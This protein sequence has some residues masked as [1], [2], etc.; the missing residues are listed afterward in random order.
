MGRLDVCKGCG[1]PEAEAD[2]AAPVIKGDGDLGP[3]WYCGECLDGWDGERNY[4]VWERHGRHFVELADGAIL[5]QSEGKGELRVTIDFLK[6]AL[7]IPADVE[8]RNVQAEP[9]DAPGS[10]RLDRP[11][12]E[13]ITFAWPEGGEADG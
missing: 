13:G 7:P 9:V 6:S 4:R 2:V 3:E 5:V 8:I 1:K 10:L 11:P 12:A